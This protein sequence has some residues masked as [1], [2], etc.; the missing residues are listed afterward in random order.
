MPFDWVVVAAGIVALVAVLVA[1]A[2]YMRLGAA[3][4][5]I[6]RVQDE[7]T[8][9]RATAAAALEKAEERL[10]QTANAI[11]QLAKAEKQL[12]ELRAERE[13]AWKRVQG[14][15]AAL[16]QAREDAALAR[17]ET[18]AMDRR[19]ADWEAAR[20]QSLEHA[21]AAAG[22]VATAL[23]NKLLDDHKRE[24]EEAKKAVEEKTQAI[25]QQFQNVVTSVANLAEQTAATKQTAET[26]WRALST[27]GGA[28]RFSEIGLENTLKSFGLVRDRDF[29]IQTSIA[30]ENGRLRPDAMIFLPNDAVLVIDS[31]ASKFVL[32]LAEAEG[33]EREAEVASNLARTMNAHVRSLC[34]KDYR[35]AIKAAYR[36][37]GRGAEVARI[38]CVM[39]V[40]NDAV[41]AKLSH[42]DPEIERTA[43]REQIVVAGPSAL[44]GILMYASMDIGLGRQ[45]E[46]QERIVHTTEALL[47]GIATALGHADAIGKRLR[48]AAES[49]KEF[50]ASVNARLLPRGRTLAQLGVKPTKAK[51]LPAHLPAIEVVEVGGVIE[52]ESEEVPQQ[53]LQFPRESAQ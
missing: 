2:A 8:R 41:L 13:A 1:L 20:A 30:A 35:G 44:A 12:D 31:K 6:A 11:G 32:E 38:L 36:D 23:S 27:P 3:K 28:G 53:V 21:K 14:A 33:G 19:V 25:A 37:A 39:Y 48:Q 16:A 45:A 34:S 9:E 46:N 47:D 52:G 24:N 4:D 50:A 5:E 10:A 40:P 26:V 29:V 7:R 51:A 42:A 22:E 15:E 18:A 49:Y 17:Q 43:R